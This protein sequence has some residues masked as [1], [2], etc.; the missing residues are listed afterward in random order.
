MELEGYGAYASGRW[1]KMGI[2]CNI[3]GPKSKYKNDITYTYEAKVVVINDEYH[4]FFADTICTLVEYLVE[5]NV[6]P[7]EVELYEIFKDEE[8]KL[9][10]GF[11]VSDEGRWLAHKELCVAL[12]ER[13]PG[14]IHENGC[15]FEDRQRNITGP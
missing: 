1:T 9:K 14:Y 6:E 15:T 4:S 2:L 7:D 11:C 8:K 13:Y 12:T 10:K 3:A 5:N